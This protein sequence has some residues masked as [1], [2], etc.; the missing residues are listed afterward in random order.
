MSDTSD[1]T[2]SIVHTIRVPREDD[3]RIRAFAERQRV[4]F[5][6]VLLDGARRLVRAEGMGD[7]VEVIGEVYDLLSTQDRR[8]QVRILRWLAERLA[9]DEV[10]RNESEVAVP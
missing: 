1:T 6:S 10:R 4:T 7:E 8:A 9:A 5:T 3:V 2:K